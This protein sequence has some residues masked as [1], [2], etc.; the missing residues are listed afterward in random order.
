MKA[1]PRATRRWAFG[2][3]VRGFTLIELLIVIAVIGVVAALAL[4]N[5]F[6]A[7]TKAKI[8]SAQEHLRLLVVA[9]QQYYEYYGVYPDNPR[10]VDGLP[11]AFFLQPDDRTYIALTSPI[12]FLPRPVYDP[13]LY[14]KQPSAGGGQNE[15]S[16]GWAYGT[17][18]TKQLAFGFKSMG[19]D[20]RPQFPFLSVNE[21]NPNEIVTLPSGEQVQVPSRAHS[22]AWYFRTGALTNLQEARKAYVHGM[23]ILPNS[24]SDPNSPYFPRVYDPTNGIRSPGDLT[25][26]PW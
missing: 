3:A 18:P 1:R 2:G 6:L 20:G 25:G 7:I 13:F 23:S 22:L 16:W 8:A 26:M 24:S 19:P 5:Y 14:R 9:A 10:E 17:D 11:N 21:K 15:L 12:P 4:N